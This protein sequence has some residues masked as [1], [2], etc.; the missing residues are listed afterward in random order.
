MSAKNLSQ[1]LGFLLYKQK[2]HQYLKGID[3]SLKKN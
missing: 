3:A 1:I 2:K